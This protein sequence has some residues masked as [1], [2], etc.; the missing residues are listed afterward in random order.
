MSLA[1]H[2]AFAADKSLVSRRGPTYI[3]VRATNETYFDSSGVLQTAGPGV[4]TFDHDP[5]TLVSLG[6]QQWEA[7]TELCLHNRDFTNAAWVKVNMTAAKDETGLDVVSNSCSSLLATAANATALQTFTIA[8]AAKVCYFDIKRLIGTGNV[9]ITIDNGT[10]W[11]SQTINVSNFT[12]VFVTQT[13]ANPV[14]GIRLVT[15]GDKVA[16]DFAGLNDGAAFPTSRIET[17]ASSVTRNLSDVSGSHNFGEAPGILY[18][19]YSQPFATGVISTS[20]IINDGTNNER[21]LLRVPVTADQNQCIVTAGGSSVVNAMV[22][23]EY[24][25]L[26]ARQAVGYALNNV[27][28]F[29]DGTAATPDTS[30]AMPTG[31]DQINIGLTEVGTFSINGHIQDVRQYNH[32]DGTAQAIEDISN[33]IF[34]SQGRGRGIGFIGRVGMG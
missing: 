29:V 12:R 26:S 33:G 22:F 16:V 20:V 24:S 23:G 10:T 13:L 18:I 32:W 17:G 14:I 4:A 15:S 6:L 9:D 11:T 27:R 28:H 19:R 5:V 34:P 21:I 31:M 7:R 8:S 25:D 2:S 3:I 30:A 1:L